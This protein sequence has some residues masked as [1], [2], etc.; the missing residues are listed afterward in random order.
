MSVH[1]GHGGRLAQDGKYDSLQFAPGQS[2]T[3][4]N[5]FNKTYFDI[6]RRPRS[7]ASDERTLR[8]EAIDDPD[9]KPLCGSMAARSGSAASG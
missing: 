9:L 5:W 7:M 4:A 6:G 2:V 8:R 3:G 1:A